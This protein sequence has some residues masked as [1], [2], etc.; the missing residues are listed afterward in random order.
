MFTVHIH[1]FQYQHTVLFVSRHRAGAQ[2]V[3]T[4]H[5]TGNL[6]ESTD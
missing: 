4:K 2:N 5:N 1:A 3:C 6:M